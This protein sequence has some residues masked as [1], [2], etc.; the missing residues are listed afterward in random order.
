MVALC[1]IL[2]AL[3]IWD[4]PARQPQHE[5]LR[6]RFVAAQRKGDTSAME[7]E[8]LLSVMSS[9]PN[10]N[11]ESIKRAIMVTRLLLC[12]LSRTMD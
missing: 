8:L 7:S 2:L 6:M 12:M 3:S 11:I 10:W 4:Y 9:R 1:S 5:A